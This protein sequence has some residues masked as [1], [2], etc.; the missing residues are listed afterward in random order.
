MFDV[1]SYLS[2]LIHSLDVMILK[3][4][5]WHAVM[6]LKTTAI[7]DE[8]NGFVDAWAQKPKPHVSLAPKNNNHSGK[9]QENKEKHSQ[10]RTGVLIV[11]CIHTYNKDNKICISVRNNVTLMAAKNICFCGGA[12]SQL[13]FLSD[14]ICPGEGAHLLLFLSESEQI[15]LGSMK[16]HVK[17]HMCCYNPLHASETR[18][19]FLSII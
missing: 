14:L 10:Q 11:L 3:S 17:V 9:K 16:R 5:V 15:E 19:F 6:D 13:I 1:I 18:V 7:W 2:R 4:Y 12:V 8:N